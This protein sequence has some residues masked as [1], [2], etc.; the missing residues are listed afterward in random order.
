MSLPWEPQN[1]APNL[2][3]LA[4]LRRGDHLSV[5][6]E[7]ENTEGEYVLGDRGL[8]A[9]FKIQGKFKQSFV[10]SKKGESILEDEQYKRPLIRFFRAAVDAWGRHLTTGD[11]VMGAFR[12]LENLR[13]TYA[14]DE[15]RR[16]KMDEILAA[17]RRELRGIRVEG[18]F[19]EPG[20]REVVLGSQSFPGMRQRILEIITDSFGAGV[21]EEYDTGVTKEFL[22]AVYGEDA[23]PQKATTMPIGDVS[24]VRKSMGVC[25]QY[26]LD[27]HVR[28]G[29]KLL[30]KRISCSKADLHE[31]YEFTD[32]DE[33]L[34]FATSQLASQAGV[35]GVPAL[36]FNQGGR[37]GQAKVP[38]IQTGGQRVIPNMGS[39]GCE[40][41][42]SG[43]Q[44]V[45]SNEQQFDGS[46][47]GFPVDG[48]DLGQGKPL[49]DFGIT[50]IGIRISAKLRRAGDRIEVE[51]HESTLR[52][53]TS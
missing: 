11:H 10:R 53:T 5:L 3:T 39:G 13:Q 2:A 18:V 48:M 26:H 20:E 43:S 12:G 4:R 19:L 22:D 16:A 15:G 51:L 1:I 50:H 25:K 23:K 32:S 29:A 42:K 24:Y 46:V 8:R 37:D 41:T 21:V 7:G 38:L 6:K 36:L 47:M 34:L 44:I 49:S 27:C 35:P 9:L 52:I 17:L 14:K 40:I 30:G 31:L 33:G 45:L 28:T